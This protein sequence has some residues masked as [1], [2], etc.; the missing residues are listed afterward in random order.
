M[1]E[2]HHT[3]DR[4]EVGRDADP[5]QTARWVNLA[6]PDVIQIH[7][8]GNPGWTTYPTQVGFT[9][10]KLRRDVLQ[11]W[12][13]I[14]DKYRYPFSVYYN[15]GRDGEIMKRHPDWNRSDVNGNEID[16]AL[17]YHSGVAERY[18]WPMIREIM[19]KY[20]PDGWWFDGSCFTV[21]L[22]YCDRCQQR[23]RRETGAA[24]PRS[25]NDPNWSAYHEMQR[26]VYREFVHKT[27]A[28][29]HEIDSDCRVAVN[30]AYSLR[31]PEK[32]DPGIAYLTGDIGN[33]VEGLSAA[34]HWY[35]GIGLPFDLMTQLNTQHA[36]KVPGGTTLREI[37][38]GSVKRGSFGP[39]PPVQ[40]QQEMAIVVANGGRFW[41]WDD[42]TPESGLIEARYEYLAR[43]VKPWLDQRRRWCLGTRRL[44]DVS[45]LNASEAH[46][47]LTDA[48]GT[49]CFSASDNRIAGAAFW[50]ARLHLNYEM[51]GNW[52]LHEQD[53]R[54]G[55]LIVEHPK[56]LARKTVA[57]IAEYV[58]RGGTLLLTGMGVLS[59]GMPIQQLCGPSQVK[60]PQK[61]EEL[62]I[63]CNGRE[64]RARHYLFRFQLDGAKP[65]MTA[66]DAQDRTHP[67]LVR[68]RVGKGTAHY[69][70]TPLLTRHGPNKIPEPVL[71]AVFEFVIPRS[72][73][74]VTTDAPNTVEI[75]LREQGHRRIVHLVNMAPGERQ[76]FRGGRRTYVKISALPPVPECV[77]RVRVEQR[78]ESVELQPQGE[79][80]NRWTYRD[81]VV[82]VRVPSFQ[83]HQIVVI[84]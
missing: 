23:F 11:V 72:S 75:V 51:V 64:S 13:D 15:I 44:P 25:R 61:A 31:M 4:Y 67:L 28:V 55:L 45:L 22:C 12:R 10:P 43:H 8:K 21:R 39:K 34:A 70:A 16:R 74:W 14:A 38:G 32:P 24:P 71:Q 81:G 60:G 50:L 19:A 59:G 35:D 1:H 7:A 46:Y 82:S 84:D 5:Q 26:Q 30:W 78:P 33:H 68:H 77:V 6:G 36:D 69:W 3:T 41:V 83:I 47:A 42:P 62:A 80:S 49:A 58:R 57:A 37:D 54:S 20:H 53:V 27:A 66:T 17:C 52:R 29:I 48:A 9:P 79:V 73:R 18:L 63:Q 76:V 65:V 56:Q 40:L 2:D